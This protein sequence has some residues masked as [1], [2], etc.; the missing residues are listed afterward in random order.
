MAGGKILEWVEIKPLE[1][2]EKLFIEIAMEAFKNFDELIII[3]NNEE[4]YSKYNIKVYNDI[5]KD[6]GPIGGIY[7]ALEYAKYDIV[8]I[9]CDMPYLNNQ[10]VERIANKMD[11]KSVISVT[12]ES[13][14]H[15]VLDIKRV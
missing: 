13:Y 12:N 4:L 9:A 7:T 11:D 6:V 5:V 10:I 3:S 2:H 1:L 8:T 15:C 14:N